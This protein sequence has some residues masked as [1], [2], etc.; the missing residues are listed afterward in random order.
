MK[1]GQCGKRL[2]DWTNLMIIWKTV[3][4]NIDGETKKFEFCSQE[5]LEQ[6]IKENNIETNQID[7]LK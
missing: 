1:C 2:Q 7:D 4:I 3:H 6:Y 5:C